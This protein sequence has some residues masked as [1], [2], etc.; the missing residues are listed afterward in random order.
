MIK[1]M[2]RLVAHLTQMKENYINL[3]SFEAFKKINIMIDRIYL[4]KL[5][6]L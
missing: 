1:I 2:I 6:S 4:L 3:S 5:F